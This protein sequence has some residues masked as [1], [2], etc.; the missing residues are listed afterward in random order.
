MLLGVLP[1]TLI[2]SKL[3]G[4]RMG[5]HIEDTMKNSADLCAEMIERQYGSDMLMLEGLAVRMATSFEDDPA[6]AMERLVSTAERYK[7]K[8]ISFSF[9]DGSTMSTDNVEMELAG[10]DNFERAIT[11]ERLLTTVIED[12]SDGK[13]VNIYSLPV[14]HSETQ[15]ILGVMSAVYPSETFENLLAAS[16]FDGEGYTYI[17]DSNG[18]VVINSHHPNAIQNL[19]NLFQYLEEHKGKAISSLKE[20]DLLKLTEKKIM[21]YLLIIK[22]LPSVTGMFSA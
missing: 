17:I 1:G 5:E 11:G 12:V 14:Y 20:K 22:N 10:I 13:Q 19:S 4:N 6:L 3:I 9:P 7:M 18:N 16:S 2:F 15:E 8:R 21:I